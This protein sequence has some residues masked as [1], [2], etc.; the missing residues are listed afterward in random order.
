MSSS[1]EAKQPPEARSG[2]PFVGRGHRVP[3][4][5][6]PGPVSSCLEVLIAAIGVVV[7]W[8]LVLVVIIMMVARRGRGGGGGDVLR[9]ETKLAVGLLHLNYQPA[10]IWQYI[11]INIY[12]RIC[13]GGGGGGGM[14]AVS[15]VVA[16]AVV[17]GS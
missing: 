7:R 16:V 8:V 14:L 12:N 6:E 10:S 4:A 13:T 1:A 3:Q 15:A 17:Y 9:G 5:E 11:Y 2:D